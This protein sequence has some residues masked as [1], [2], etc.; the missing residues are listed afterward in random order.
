MTDVNESE[1]CNIMFELDEAS[2]EERT[3]LLERLASED[4]AAFRYI[5][6]FQLGEI[7]I[8]EYRSEKIKGM[9]KKGLQ[10]ILDKAMTNMTDAYSELISGEGREEY[11][12]IERMATHK[13]LGGLYTIISEEAKHLD[14][15]LEEQLNGWNFM[16]DTFKSA[17]YEELL[18][19]TEHERVKSKID[20]K[21]AE[22]KIKQQKVV[23]ARTLLQEA[24]PFLNSEEQKNVVSE[25]VRMVIGV[26][27]QFKDQKI[28]GSWSSDI[29]EVNE[30]CAYFY[31]NEFFQGEDTEDILKT[32]S[33]FRNVMILGSDEM[34]ERVTPDYRKA[35]I[36]ADEN[37]QIEKKEK[38]SIL[39]FAV[40]KLDSDVE[41]NM[42]YS[43]W[44]F[45]DREYDKTR[46][47]YDKIENF[48]DVDED[49]LSRIK[50][51]KLVIDFMTAGKEVE[52]LQ[53]LWETAEEYTRTSLSK[54]SPEYM[55]T[56]GLIA[57]REYKGF[58]W[59]DSGDQHLRVHGIVLDD[60]KPKTYEFQ[61]LKKAIFYSRENPTTL[62]T[63]VVSEKLEK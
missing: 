63:D 9:D 18:T 25:I 58:G 38:T 62:V 28:A 41:I 48:D 32:N 44:L 42:R 45:L 34:K 4:D 13:I 5:S 39:R 52:K 6:Q 33:Y 10:E 36:L 23:E 8:R 61:E 53:A 59:K 57:L 50:F 7:F 21:K 1:I 24:Y 26:N 12:E 35:I 56:H 16:L 40:I 51:N 47:V 19:T 15:T 49:V 22:I 31:L 30:Q 2:S 54:G 27:K 11:T 46:A 14:Q 55:F 29:A 37:E 17:E 60:W 3:E 20:L 43:N